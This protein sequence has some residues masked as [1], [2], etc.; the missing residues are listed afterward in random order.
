MS[1]D[2]PVILDLAKNVVKYHNIVMRYPLGMLM[3]SNDKLLAT[4][5]KFPTGFKLALSSCIGP[6]V[7]RAQPPMTGRLPTTTLRLC[8]GVF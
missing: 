7:G 1:V 3:F 4:R 2:I 6:R 5:F 8:S